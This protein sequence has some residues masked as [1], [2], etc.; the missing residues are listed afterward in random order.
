M[1]EGHA[2]GKPLVVMTVY[3]EGGGETRALQTPARK[4]L[5]KLLERAGLAER[6]PRVV[7]CGGRSQALHDFGIAFRKGEVAVLLVDSEDSVTEGSSAAAHL[8]K[9]G[10]WD[11]SGADD[12]LHLMVQVMETWFLTQPKVLAE[13]FGKN[14]EPSVLPKGPGLERVSKNIVVDALDKASRHC[15]SGPYS[16]KKQQGFEILELL[17]V[18][19]IEQASP[20]AKRFF[21]FLRQ[22]CA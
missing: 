3:V 12:R 18:E 7:A 14:F 6:L 9:R 1:A 20:F 10:E 11:G 2:R 8:Q 4:A 15:A 13:H 17:S 19:P 16:R 21:E 22:Q 5:R